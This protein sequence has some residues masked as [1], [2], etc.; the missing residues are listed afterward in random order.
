MTLTGVGVAVS[1]KIVSAI[2][3]ADASLLLPIGS[4]VMVPENIFD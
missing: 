2:S 1:F 3:V 4:T